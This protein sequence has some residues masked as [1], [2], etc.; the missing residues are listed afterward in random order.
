MLPTARRVFSTR[1]TATLL[2][3]WPRATASAAAEADA[4]T[5]AAAADAADAAIESSHRGIGAVDE[6]VDG[7][8][9][10]G[11]LDDHAARS[12]AHHRASPHNR[13]RA[14]ALAPPAQTPDGASNVYAIDDEYKEMAFA[15]LRMTEQ[16][17]G[18]ALHAHV[19]K[20]RENQVAAAAVVAPELPPDAAIT[21][22]RVANPAAA[23]DPDPEA[24]RELV[25]ESFTDPIID[26]IAADI[27]VA[28]VSP[29]ARIHASVLSAVASS[30]TRGA[31]WETGDS[32]MSPLDHHQI[33]EMMRQRV[34][35]Q[36]PS[37][38]VP[39]SRR[40]ATTSGNAQAI[41]GAPAGHG[42]RSAKEHHPHKHRG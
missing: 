12:M 40:S 20:A 30:D 22:P 31:E 33:D 27:L 41:S 10:A 42:P 25:E 4:D 37:A 11:F 8:R 38:P 17:F 1:P 34:A 18:A 9:E 29:A 7:L 16:D 36:D 32:S 26:T 2:S 6:G 14:P 21:A 3:R 23:L 13:A 19:A 5:A 35:R 15:V 39:G 24:V 28:E